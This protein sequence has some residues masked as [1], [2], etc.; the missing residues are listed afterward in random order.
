MLLYLSQQVLYGI[1]D[2]SDG[3]WRRGD[4]GTMNMKYSFTVIYNTLSKSVLSI[5]GGIIPA[6]Q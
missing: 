2:G 5:P 6:K 1:G 3:N 4:D